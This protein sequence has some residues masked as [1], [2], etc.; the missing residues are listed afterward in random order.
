V[1]KKDGNLYRRS[2]ALLVN[3][4]RFASEGPC[5]LPDFDHPPRVSTAAPRSAPDDGSVLSGIRRRWDRL[6]ARF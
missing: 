3:I 1:E 2:Y 5:E 4:V 6:R